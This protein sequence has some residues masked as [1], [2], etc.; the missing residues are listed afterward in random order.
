MNKILFCSKL[1]ANPTIKEDID[2]V[3][4]TIDDVKILIRISWQNGYV[5]YLDLTEVNSVEKKLAYANKITL[6]ALTKF[7]YR[8]TPT[9]LLPFSIYTTKFMK[10]VYQQTLNI[11]FGFTTSY[12]EL[13]ERL[14]TSPR[15]IGM[16]MK[17]NPIPLIIPCHRVIGKKGQLTGFSSGLKIKEKLL[18][19]EQ[20]KKVDL[21]IYTN[22]K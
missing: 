19:L 21:T 13:S 10:R 16:A 15:A 1:K 9:L 20:T 2:T 12:K 4:V 14:S 22:I 3:F 5:V 17:K 7:L 8:Q 6:N 18:K 11:P